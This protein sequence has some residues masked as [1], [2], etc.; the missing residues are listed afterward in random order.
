M[1]D[2][3]WFVSSDRCHLGDPE[4]GGRR[5][6]RRHAAAFIFP[7]RVQHPAPPE[8]GGRLQPLRVAREEQVPEQQQ[9][10]RPQRQQQQSHGGKPTPAAARPEWTFTQLSGYSSKPA[11][12]Q[13]ISSLV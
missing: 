11:S 1:Y 7:S 3:T 4:R 9:Q 13:S 8:P 5:P 2:W 12:R 10:P 6:T